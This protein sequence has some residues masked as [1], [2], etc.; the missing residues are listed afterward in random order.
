MFKSSR[1]SK[2]SNVA[3]GFSGREPDSA[4]FAVMPMF[5]PKQVHGDTIIRVDA[6]SNPNDISM[7]EADAIWTTERSLA[8][9]VKTADCVPMLLADRAGKGVMAVHLGWRGAANGLA[10]KSI[11]LFC[12]ELGVP[13]TDIVAAIGPCIGFAAFEVGR[14]VVDA[15]VAQVSSA[16]LFTQSDG[17]YHVDLAGWVERQLQDAGVVEIDKLGLCTFSDPKNFF[18]YRRGHDVGRQRSMIARL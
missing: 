12:S 13:A 6:R 9:G 16:G 11:H 8:I 18:S 5:L 2:V 14:E 4:V 7:Q 17:S 10:K 1:L 3:H 15:L